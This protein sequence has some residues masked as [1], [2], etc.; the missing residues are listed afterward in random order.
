MHP[1]RVTSMIQRSLILV[2]LLLSACG[3]NDER[4]RSPASKLPYPP[5]MR[6]GVVDSY[7]GTKVA[8][9]YRWLEETGSAS[10]QSWIEAQNSFS[11]PRLEA[12]PLRTQ[13]KQR[14]TQLWNYERYGI[15][16]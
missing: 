6:V 15:P 14:L 12:I 2:A 16:L 5:A 9:P 3:T 8:D 7:H 10:A 13:I 4:S 1:Q 11:Q